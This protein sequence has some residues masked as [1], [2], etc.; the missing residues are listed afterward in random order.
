MSESASWLTVRPGWKVLASDG[1]Q[2]GEVDEVAG[3]ETADVFDGVVVATSALGA[4]RYVLAEQVAA[5]ADETVRLT[6]SPREVAALGEYLEPATS[7]EIEADN[8]PESG[9]AAEIREIEGDVAAPIAGHEH[10]IGLVER[11]TLLF[12]RLRG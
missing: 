9:L 6:L 2:V 11:V 7:A 5:I 10:R 3:D 4:P 8:K 1:T 12:R